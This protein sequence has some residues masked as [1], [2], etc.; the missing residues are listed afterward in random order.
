MPDS[1]D[2]RFSTGRNWSIA[3]VKKIT[4]LC[5]Q[6]STGHNR[7][8]FC[9]LFFG[10]NRTNLSDALWLTCSY[11][12]SQASALVEGGVE[13]DPPKTQS[14]VPC[15]TKLKNILRI[16]INFFCGDDQFD[17]KLCVL[18]NLSL[19]NPGDA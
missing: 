6:I 3:I 4:P 18:F 7:N 14:D 12:P 17:E 11:C 1:R 8:T 15:C 5:I 13:F 10:C 16:E 19:Q 2:N 9:Y